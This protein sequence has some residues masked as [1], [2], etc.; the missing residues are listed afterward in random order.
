MGRPR[1]KGSGKKAI[2]AYHRDEP[3]V[4]ART[5]YLLGK[6]MMKGRRGK[7]PT[8]SDQDAVFRVY[9]SITA[10]NTRTGQRSFAKG[11]KGGNRN[12]FIGALKKTNRRKWK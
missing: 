5:L 10:M 6:L 1:K 11:W 8:K 2:Q 4:T 9:Q 12:G 3:R 7:F